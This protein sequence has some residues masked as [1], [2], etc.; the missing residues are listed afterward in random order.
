MNTRPVKTISRREVLRRTTALSALAAAQLAWPAWLP[1]LS[2]NPDG[3]RGDVLVCIFLRGGADALNVIVPHGEDAYYTARPRLAIARP[4]D[5]R[6]D[7]AARTLD[8]DGFFGLH[9][10]L[11]PVLPIFAAGGMKAV[12]AAGS[13]ALTRSHFDA[14]NIME[15][16]TPQSAASGWIGRH[17]A[18]LENPNNTPVRAVG[19]G[20]A[21]QFS[22]R[23][24]VNAVSIKS[25]VD[26]HLGGRKDASDAMLKAL[27]TLYAAGDEAIRLAGAQTQ[28]VL[29][30]VSRINIADY[31]A[32]NGATY[33]D[34]NEFD[35]ALMQTAALIKAEVGL[36]VS[37]IDLGGWD[38]HQD[39]APDLAAN[40]ATLAKGLA[41]FHADMGERMRGIT[42]VIMS[43]F[44]RRVTE[45]ASAGTDHG[46]GG[47]LLL[48]GAHL[49]GAKVVA[50]WP[51]LA[52]E[53]LVNGDVAITTDYRD[54]L[55]EVIQKRLRNPN[56]A[57]VFP[58][59]TVTDRGIVVAGS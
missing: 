13:P 31:R 9:P 10:A 38:T 25:I 20:D 16:G 36:E 11:A 4:D 27:N 24:S 39:E 53:Q 49:T 46:Y 28:A 19:W 45:N 50:Q 15:R 40:L 14:M 30:L 56:V 2:F 57:A 59:F 18:S 47:A 23:G 55:A 1:R 44:G 51:G 3:P 17:L 22:L 58:G 41:A 21:L 12:H 52:P 42:V 29:D 6:A 43:E 5:A 34:Q 48:M 37:A 7:A 8:L 33:D 35:M 32:S 26:Y 54:V